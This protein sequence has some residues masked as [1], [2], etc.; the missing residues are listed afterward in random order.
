MSPRIGLAEL[1]RSNFGVLRSAVAA[2]LSFPSR[3]P[4][5]NHLEP[6]Q[7]AIPYVSLWRSIAMANGE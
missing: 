4:L 3:S 6:V 5:D 1:A 7:A 2:T